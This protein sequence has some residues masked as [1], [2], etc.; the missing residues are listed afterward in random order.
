MKLSKIRYVGEI[1]LMHM[2]F[3]VPYHS[4]FVCCYDDNLDFVTSF[5][6]RNASL[7]G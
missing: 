1:F 5:N 6:R 2:H 3:L 7:K 4:P